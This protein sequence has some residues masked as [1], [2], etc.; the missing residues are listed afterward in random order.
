VDLEETVV[1]EIEVEEVG[2]SSAAVQAW[3]VFFST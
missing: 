3:E 2:L 1:A